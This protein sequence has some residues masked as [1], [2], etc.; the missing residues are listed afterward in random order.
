MVLPLAGALLARAA[1]RAPPTTYPVIRRLLTLNPWATLFTA[2]RD[3]IYDGQLPDWTA[4][5]A[6]LL[7][8]L[9]LLA[10]TTLFFKRVEP[11]FAKVL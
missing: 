3:V 10:L 11:A 2:Y 9:V 1:D 6:V 8:S 7:G 4:L 5:G